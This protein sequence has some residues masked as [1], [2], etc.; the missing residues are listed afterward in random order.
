ML[1]ANKSRWLVAYVFVIG[2]QLLCFL[3]CLCCKVQLAQALQCFGAPVPALDPTAGTANRNIRDLLPQAADGAGGNGSKRC[4]AL[5]KYAKFGCELA[6][7]QAAV[8][9]QCLTYL[10]S[11]ATDRCA[12]ARAP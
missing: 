3:C 11:T 1:A 4:I 5:F 2:L 12:S 6:L 7:K 9:Q 8:T 10:S